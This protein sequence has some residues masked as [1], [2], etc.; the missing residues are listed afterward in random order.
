VRDVLER[1]QVDALVVPGCF[2]G[3]WGLKWVNG[4]VNMRLS[5][6]VVFWGLG[7]L[8]SGWVSE[9]GKERPKMGAWKGVTSRGGQTG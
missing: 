3:V 5:C 4:C 9:G 7:V 1:A 8:E 6:L 2:W